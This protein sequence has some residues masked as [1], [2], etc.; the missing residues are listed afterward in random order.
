MQQSQPE[1]QSQR[2]NP[3]MRRHE[4]E[5]TPTINRDFLRPSEQMAKNA[6]PMSL[7]KMLLQKNAVRQQQQ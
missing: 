2:Y 6:E 4:S 3:Q 1:I 5:T 7:K